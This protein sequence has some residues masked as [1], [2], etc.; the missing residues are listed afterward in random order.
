MRLFVR[1]DASDHIERLVHVR[2]DLGRGRAWIRHALNENALES[3]LRLILDDALHKPEYY[4][5]DA[6]VANAETMAILE[7]VATGL[8]FLRV[9]TIRGF[10]FYLFYSAL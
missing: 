10:R 8:E 9:R 4:A 7:T 1:K 2:S 3:Y 6:F 5:P